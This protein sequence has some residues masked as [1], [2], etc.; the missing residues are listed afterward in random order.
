MIEDGREPVV[1]ALPARTMNEPG[2]PPLGRGR[3][4]PEDALVKPLRCDTRALSPAG[5]FGGN[6][7]LRLAARKRRPHEPLAPVR[8]AWLFFFF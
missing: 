7:P 4:Y 3:N 2:L 5:V 1:A 6:A 8:S